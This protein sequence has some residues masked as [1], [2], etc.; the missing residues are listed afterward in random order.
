VCGAWLVKDAPKVGRAGDGLLFETCIPGVGRFRLQGSRR[1]PGPAREASLEL[2]AADGAWIGS[3][4]DNHVTLADDLLGAEIRA[5]LRTARTPAQGGSAGVVEVEVR[6]D[7]SG[8]AGRA[9]PQG[10]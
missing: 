10:S 1:V 6:F 7:C 2:D 8:G 3:G 9:A 5:T 4:P